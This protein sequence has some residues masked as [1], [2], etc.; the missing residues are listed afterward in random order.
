MKTSMTCVS[1]TF[2]RAHL[3]I[4]HPDSPG[5]TSNWE[6][7]ADLTAQELSQLVCLLTAAVATTKVVAMHVHSGRYSGVSA[8]DHSTHMFTMFSCTGEPLRALPLT[9][10]LLMLACSFPEDMDDI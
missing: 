6:L 5:S 9:A 3:L 1:S 10:S 2:C 7:P 4:A 8:K